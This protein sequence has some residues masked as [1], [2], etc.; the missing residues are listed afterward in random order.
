MSP[1]ASTSLLFGPPSPANGMNGRGETLPRPASHNVV[2]AALRQVT[3]DWATL[4]DA[5]P[6]G[7]CTF[8]NDCLVHTWNAA[9]ERIFG[10]NSADVVGHKLPINLDSGASDFGGLRSLV[11]TG[12]SF[13]DIEMVHRRQDGSTVDVSLCVSPLRRPDGSIRGAMAIIADISERKRAEFEQQKFVSLVEN[14]S[15]FIAIMD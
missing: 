8:D 12:G 14:S 11:L 10:W 2:E 5:A 3:E 1:T 4:L 7:I 9:C 13:S 6:V 15:D